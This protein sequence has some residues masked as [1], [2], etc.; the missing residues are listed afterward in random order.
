[1]AEWEETSAIQAFYDAACHLGEAKI[2]ELP[3]ADDVT[4]LYSG[5]VAFGKLVASIDLH[6]LHKTNRFTT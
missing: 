3:V 1:M 4:S 5:S 6:P 2:I